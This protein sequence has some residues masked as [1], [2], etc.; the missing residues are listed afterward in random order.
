MAEPPLTARA[1]CS[2]RGPRSMRSFGLRGAR[3]SGTELGN[4]QAR[5]AVKIE[6][7]ECLAGR[8]SCS[9]ARKCE[10][11][12][13]LSSA[14]SCIQ[15]AFQVDMLRESYSDHPW[16]GAGVEGQCVHGRTCC[17]RGLE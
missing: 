9:S 15:G 17:R 4:D 3:G 1:T 11:C 12:R 14:R 16:A 5:V 2:T 8:S 13:W 7:N 10:R 6:S